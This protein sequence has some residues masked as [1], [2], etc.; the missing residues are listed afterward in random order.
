[1]SAARD[2]DRQYRV[3]G[4]EDQP[5]PVVLDLV[6][7]VRF[8]HQRF[9]GERLDSD[10]GVLGFEGPAA[11]EPVDGLAPADGH[12]PG[13]RIEGYPRLRP[14]AQSVNEGV[15]GQVFG[16]PHVTDKAGQAGD[17]PAE[18]YA[19]HRLDRGGRIG[20]GHG[21]RFNHRH[22]PGRALLRAEDGT[23]P[24]LSVSEHT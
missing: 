1:M 21:H 12:Q 7:D 20:G 22:G 6:T 10:P 16:P 5:E 24:D 2:R 4:N 9:V 17:Q 23:N 13:A 3:A 8:H 19:E 18:L 11:A 14:L 15:L